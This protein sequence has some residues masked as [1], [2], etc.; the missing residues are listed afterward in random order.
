V[1]VS[2]EAPPQSFTEK[3]IKTWRRFRNVNWE[4]DLALEPNKTRP[5]D[6]QIAE[7]STIKNIHP[8]KRTLTLAN[9]KA[10]KGQRFQFRQGANAYDVYIAGEPQAPESRPMV[11]GKLNT[12]PG[13]DLKK[14]FVLY[15]AFD[16]N[17][18]PV[19]R[20]DRI[21][22]SYNDQRLSDKAL[23][24]HKD[25][26]KPEEPA[27]A[28][29]NPTAPGGPGGAEPGGPGGDR[30]SAMQK[31]MGGRGGKFGNMGGEDRGGGAGG[32][33]GYTD[34]SGDRTPNGLRRDRYLQTTETSRALPVGLVL[35]VDQSNIQDVLIA[36]ADSRLRVQTTQV[37]F[38]HVRGIRPADAGEGQPGMAERPGAPGA[39]PPS[40]GKLMPGVG[41]GGLRRG[42]G[43]DDRPAGPRGG[44]FGGPGGMGGMIPPPGGIPPG[45][46]YGAPAATGQDEDDPNL[47]EL[48]VYCIATLYERYP[49]K[50]VD[51][52]ADPAKSAEKKP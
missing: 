15:Q 7:C 51:E 9:S 47:V 50:K 8:G 28:G 31:A 45:G 14:P 44:K 12:P 2:N 19:K 22:L 36:L 25:L 43:D 23:K 18:A 35:I 27:D 6:L 32:F 3:G 46:G 10:D 4:I 39:P 41:T 16:W 38:Q 48:S 42:G 49:P 26:P 21:E 13:L 34:T 29:A 37:A 17:T 5:S 40:M 30:A 33:G 52:T 20:V 24:P 1:D 11:I